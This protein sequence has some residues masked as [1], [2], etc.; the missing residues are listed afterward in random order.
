MLKIDI[1]QLREAKAEGCPAFR[2]GRVYTAPLL[3]WLIEK[4][5]R[6]ADP[7][8]AE[9]VVGMVDQHLVDNSEKGGQLPKSHWDCKKAQLDY[10][11]ALFRFEVEKEKY[12]VLNEMTVAVGKM[13]VGFRTALNMLPANAARW[14]VGL[15]D[16]H[17]IK[18]RL[19]SEVD[20]VLNSLGRCEYLNADF[21]E[22][23]TKSL[24]FD[25]ETEALL[26]KINFPGQDRV[27]LYE[28]IGRVVV[29][30]IAEFGRSCLSDLL[31]RQLPVEG[32]VR[33]EDEVSQGLWES[34]PCSQRRN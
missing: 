11:R 31:H 26:E 24:P 1:S 23:I 13:L 9:T 19:E 4:R 29:R 25:A 5:Q 6:R 28:I 3:A 33:R 22:G 21:A 12:V 7:A 34:S 10:E 14:L 27:A 17:Q 30:A 2:S 32:Y 20:A 16:F 18:E 8:A 15:R